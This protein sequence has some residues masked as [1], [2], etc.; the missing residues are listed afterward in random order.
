M[1][2]RR[3][4]HEVVAGPRCQRHRK[5]HWPASSNTMGPMRY[6]PGAIS[7][8]GSAGWLEMGWLQARTTSGLGSAPS[9]GEPSRRL[10]TFTVKYTCPETEGR[11]LARRSRAR[12]YLQV[13]SSLPDCVVD[14]GPVA[15]GQR[16]RGMPPHRAVRGRAPEGARG[17]IH[18]LG[19]SRR[20]RDLHDG[21][22]VR[23]HA[24]RVGGAWRRAACRGA[25]G[26][27]QQAEA[28]RRAGSP[29]KSSRCPGMRRARAT[30]SGIK[31]KTHDKF[32]LEESLDVHGVVRAALSRRDHR[33]WPSQPSGDS[34]RRASADR[35][36][37]SYFVAKRARPLLHRDRHQ[38]L[39]PDRDG[40][41]DRRGCKGRKVVTVAA[42]RR[43]RTGPLVVQSLLLEAR[44]FGA[45]TRT[46]PHPALARVCLRIEVPQHAAHSRPEQQRGG[47]RG[48]HHQGEP[49]TQQTKEEK[50]PAHSGGVLCPSRPA[51][52]PRARQDNFRPGPLPSRA[53]SLRTSRRHHDPPGT[54]KRPR[55]CQQSFELH[56]DPRLRVT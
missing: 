13:P 48:H 14:G 10:V 41:S 36:G 1:A 38:R 2:V 55:H 24:M 16:P 11:M 53:L 20:R 25:A 19:A 3:V 29:M 4:G 15:G 56:A 44:A 30:R 5:G 18:G 22:T 49:G 40:D 21:A 43:D 37:R 28:I 32:L 8:E 27:I 50:Q 23:E 6:V 52:N 12:S 51:S 7:G 34:R 45:P 54:S 47:D 9:S 17:V 42:H 35:S 31:P 39:R 46:W 33:Q 26:A